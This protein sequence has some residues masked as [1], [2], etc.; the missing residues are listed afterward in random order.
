ML[1][2]LGFDNGVAPPKKLV[3]TNGK[4]ARVK[5]QV[6]DASIVFLGKS[7]DVMA[8]QMNNLQQGL[9]LIQTDRIYSDWWIGEV[10]AVGSIN[11]STLNVEVD[12]MPGAGNPDAPGGSDG[13][14]CEWQDGL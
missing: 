13:G 9:Q 10:W 7:R 8:Q 1:I 14:G 6:V 5:M 2:S 4:L 3:D 12:V 11:G